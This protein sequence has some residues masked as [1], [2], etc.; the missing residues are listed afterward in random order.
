MQQRK[1]LLAQQQSNRWIFRCHFKCLCF[2]FLHFVFVVKYVYY[3]LVNGSLVARL[4]LFT[5]TAACCHSPKLS[6]IA[7]AANLNSQRSSRADWWIHVFRYAYKYIYT[8]CIYRYIPICDLAVGCAHFCHQPSN[9]QSPKAQTRSSTSLSL[10]CKW[11]DVR[12][13]RNLCTYIVMYICLYT[14]L[15]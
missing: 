15:A 14:A 1:L 3:N 13:T 4:L 11:R 8:L 12:L 2:C 10:T 6:D 5:L 9:C 7:A